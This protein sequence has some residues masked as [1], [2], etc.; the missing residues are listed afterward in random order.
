M[1]PSSNLSLGRLATDVSATKFG[2]KVA[3][4][5]FMGKSTSDYPALERH[6]ISWTFEYTNR[7]VNVERRRASCQVRA[8]RDGYHGHA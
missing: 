2:G 3:D 4:K 5:G 1:N 6:K 8:Q 7:L